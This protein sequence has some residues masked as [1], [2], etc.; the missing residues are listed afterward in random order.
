MHWDVLSHKKESNCTICRDVDGPRNCHT[1]EISQKEIVLIEVLSAPLD[2]LRLTLIP[3]P[4]LCDSQCWYQR[5]AWECCVTL[6]LRHWSGFM[7]IVSPNFWLKLYL[8]WSHT[9]S[10]FP[11]ITYVSLNVDTWMGLWTVVTVDLN[12]QSLKGR[13]LK[14]LVFLDKVLLRVVTA[15]VLEQK[16]IHNAFLSFMYYL[17][18]IKKN[19][20][21]C[22][23]SVSQD[24]MDCIFMSCW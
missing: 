14:I 6:W 8:R 16:T 19:I 24:I 23:P 20:S 4:A 3:F 10:N 11:V 2:P 7:G 5:E 18:I 9:M 12:S 13:V 21:N 15:S 22:R 1:S 17:K